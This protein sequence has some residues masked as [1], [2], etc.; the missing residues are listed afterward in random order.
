MTSDKLAALVGVLISLL[1]AYLPGLKSWFNK[2]SSEAKGGITAGVTVLAALAVYGL[3][4]AG[5]F[6]QLGV[7]C[8][9][10]GFQQLV[11]II[12]GALVGMGGTYVTLVRPFKNQS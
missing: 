2:Q 1:F 7:T 9:Q 11:T 8:S 12:I 4:C 10:G 6:T 5:W 3:S